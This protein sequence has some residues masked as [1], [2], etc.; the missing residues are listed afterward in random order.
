MLFLTE[1]TPVTERAI[2]TA[3]FMLGV[4]STKP[5]NRTVWL[6]VSTL[7]C[8]TLSEG[9][10][11]ISAFTFAVIQLSATIKPSYA[12]GAFASVRQDA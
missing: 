6:R 9:S 10:L 7:I 3:L 1:I 12:P 4:A 2:A 5:L 11:K 8:D